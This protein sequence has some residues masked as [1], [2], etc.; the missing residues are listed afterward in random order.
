MTTP[1]LVFGANGQVAQEIGRIAPTLGFTATL[2][3]R[4]RVNLMSQDGSAL[5][6]ELRPQA[7]IN[8]AAYTAVDRAEQEP[9]AAYRLNGDIPG[10]LAQACKDRGLPFVHI[11]TDYVFDGSKDGPYIE[12]DPRAPLGVYGASK[13]QGEEAI[14]AVG[15]DYAIVRTA[16]VYSA[17]GANFVKTM[18]RLAAT[19]DELG[20]VG[21]QYGCPTW[22]QDVAVATLMLSQRLIDGDSAAKGLFHAAGQG[23]A[24]WA[25]FAQAIFKGSAARGGPT[26]RVK[27]ITTA[28]YPTPA[29]RPANSRLAGERLYQV[30]G[31][32]PGAWR[33]SL[34][35]CLDELV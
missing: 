21:D 12:T 5:L 26:A 9:A 27:S 8:A 14:T 33:D 34:S 6:D 29:R 2:A 32:R 13:A 24:S 28:D 16:W 18:L 19:R 20:V 4:D 35:S 11:S 10:L 7:V 30:I 15:G 17:F 22:A 1:L 3:G 23:D 31:W 25:D